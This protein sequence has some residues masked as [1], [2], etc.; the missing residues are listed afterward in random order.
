MDDTR[1]QVGAIAARAGTYADRVL[2][3]HVRPTKPLRWNSGPTSR[4][5]RAARLHPCRGSASALLCSP[6]K[7]R[8][9][10][11]AEARGSR[12]PLHGLL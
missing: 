10:L 11:D 6:V 12:A 5:L 4:P 9:R 8:R 7:A 2:R 1:Q 3:C